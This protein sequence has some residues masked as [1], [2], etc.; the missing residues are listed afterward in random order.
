MK[1]MS[2]ISFIKCFLL[3]DTWGNW[4]GFF[5]CKGIKKNSLVCEIWEQFC[6]FT[7]KIFVL[8]QFPRVITWV[9]EIGRQGW[10]VRVVRHLGC[11]GGGGGGKVCT[12]CNYH[13]HQDTWQLD[14]GWHFLLLTDIRSLLCHLQ[15]LLQH[16]TINK[17]LV[18]QGFVVS[19][20]WH[21]ARMDSPDLTLYT[22]KASFTIVPASSSPPLDEDEDR[23]D[24]NRYRYDHMSD[25]TILPKV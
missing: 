20:D 17:H 7:P 19:C 4:I 8:L 22:I 12:M 3:L 1:S 21:K 9:T 24:R 14:T 6:Y 11:Q 10:R 2:F 15:S 5:V 23:F 25:S 16:L 13:C 18:M